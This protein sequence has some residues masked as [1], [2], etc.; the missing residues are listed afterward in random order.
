MVFSQIDINIQ[1][2][3]YKIIFKTENVKGIVY[4]YTD[5]NELS[6]LVSLYGHCIPLNYI[7]Y[8]S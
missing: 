6:N 3:K 7:L 8:M 5:N 2:G 4:S 1:N